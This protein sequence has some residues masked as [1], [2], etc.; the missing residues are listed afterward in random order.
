MNF[1]NYFSNSEKSGKEKASI[2][3]QIVRTNPVLE[4]FGNAKTVRNNNSSR[5]GKFIR[6]HFNAGGRI[7]GADI[8]HCN[9]SLCILSHCFFNFYV[10]CYQI[11]LHTKR[12]MI[13]RISSIQPSRN[14][15]EN[16]T[17]HLYFCKE[18]VRFAYNS[19]INYRSTG[20]IQS[21]Q[22]GAGRTLLSYLLSDYV[23]SSLRI[24]R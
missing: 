8:E 15:P 20:K 4:A 10:I 22:S 6:I 9:Q 24:E 1:L 19:T 13:Y 17:T 5:F 23:R 18:T 16:S 7:A 11:N 2:E 12:E 21:Y 14:F 3:D